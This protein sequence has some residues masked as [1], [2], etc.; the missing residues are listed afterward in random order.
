VQFKDRASVYTFDG[1]DVG[2]IDRVV[3]NPN[4][5]EVTHIVV[6]KGFLFTEDKIVPLNL[7]ISATEDRVVLQVNDA[8]DLHALP[9]FE[10]THYLP[11][12]DNEFH[13]TALEHELATPNYWYPPMGLQ[14]YGYRTGYDYP[15]YTIETE[16]NI[17]E[18]T[19]ALQEGARVM[20]VDSQHVGNVARIF[21]E[22]GSHQ[23]SHILISD[24]IIFKHKKLVPVSWIREM[25]ED[26]VYLGVGATMLDKLPEYQE[27]S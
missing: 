3:L 21:T 23:A 11:L 25:Q 26:E 19:V 17:P 10:E 15:A 12:D 5:K 13:T 9:Q 14:S 2:N 4:T 20:S 24:G 1:Q 8:D 22:S 27:V 16:Q 7:I 6:R 18:G